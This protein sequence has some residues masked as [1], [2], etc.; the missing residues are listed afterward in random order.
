MRVAL[1]D[2]LAYTPPYD[3]SLATALAQRGH[4]VTLLTSRFPHGDAPTPAGYDREELFAPLST[5]LFRRSRVRVALKG[6]EYAPS[7]AR[8]TRRIARL[9]PDIVHV[10]WLPRPELDLR[11]LRRM[12]EERPIV[13]TAHDVL[14]RRAK[15]RPVWP[16]VLETAERVVVHSFRAVEQLVELGIG[17]ERIA[18]IPHPVFEGEEL[19]PPE[20][21]TLLFFGLIRDYKGLD[22]L[23]SALPDIHD[24]RLI[25][26]GDPL[27]PVEPVDLDGRVEWRLRFLPQDEVKDLMARAA[28]V[29]L[30]YRQLDSSG[31]LAT[32]IGYRRPVVVTDVGSLGEIVREFGA[33]EVVP[34]GDPRALAEATTRL[35]EPEALAAA[36]EG[37]ERAAAA[38]TWERSAEEHDRVYREV[39]R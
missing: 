19:P 27:D 33:G 22:V 1:V 21:R 13:L 25:V 28:A 30:P 8:L 10:Q 2:P 26:A 5:R 17:R 20:G 14:P 38:L 3:H 23:L 4:A 31:V 35:L 9:D 18:R 39:R 6:L 36:R 24:A 16:E 29:V 11:W 15:A 34:P 12:A 7:V 32:A 37:A